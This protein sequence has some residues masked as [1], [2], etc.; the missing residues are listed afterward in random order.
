MRIVASIA[1]TNA[2]E[3]QIANTTC[4]RPAL[5]PADTAPPETP[6]VPSPASRDIDT[7]SAPIVAGRKTTE[8]ERW[9]HIPATLNSLDN[10]R[11]R[12]PTLRPRST[13]SRT[14]CARPETAAGR[15]TETFG[16]YAEPFD[17]L[18]FVKKFTSTSSAVPP[19]SD[20][21]GRSA[22]KIGTTEELHAAASDLTGLS[23]FGPPDYLEGLEVVLT[24]YEQEADL[25]PDGGQMVRGNLCDILVAIASPTRSRTARN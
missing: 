15:C 9:D 13:A 17:D 16:R 11:E 20:Y 6:G 10:R 12:D 23:A 4:R 25:T 7:M 18:R 14:I 3:Q 19:T 2:L 8:V 21:S 22:D 24:S 5:S 1:T